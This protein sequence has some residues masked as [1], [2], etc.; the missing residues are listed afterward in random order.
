MH[1]MSLY[2]AMGGQPGLLRL[3]DA[4]HE[5]CLSDPIVAHAFSHGFHPDHTVRLAAYW[6]ESL[7]GPAAYPGEIGTETE[8]VRMHSGNGSAPEMHAAGAS[9]FQAALADVGLTQGPVRDR[10]VAWWAESTERLAAYPDSA[11]DVPHGLRLPV[12][13]G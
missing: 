4:W 5:G 13:E 11:A 10:M 7:G 9:C 1:S 6:A 2:Q 3:A 12:F 8:V